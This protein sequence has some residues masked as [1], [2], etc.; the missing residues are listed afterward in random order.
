MS[1]LVEFDGE[2][3]RRIR[4]V[5][6]FDILN[7]GRPVFQVVTRVEIAARLETEG[8]E[9]NLEVIIDRKSVV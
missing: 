7:L 1:L 3:M 5:Y 9:L 8:A 2:Q 4:F 6:G